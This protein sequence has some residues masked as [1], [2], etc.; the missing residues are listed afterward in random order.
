V[1]RL[2]LVLAVTS[3]AVHLAPRHACAQGAAG[4]GSTDKAIAYCAAH[5]NDTTRCVPPTAS[6]PA[7]AV[8]PPSSGNR[9]A[10]TENAA[11]NATNSCPG[12]TTGTRKL[13]DIT[14]PQ[15]PP[16]ATPIVQADNSAQQ[17]YQQWLDE[18][19][20]QNAVQQ[21]QIQQQNEA[22][23]RQD[24]Q[25]RIQ[26]QQNFDSGYEA[27]Q[28]GGSLLYALMVRHRMRSYCKKHRDGEWQL[29]SGRIVA[30]STVQ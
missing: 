3:I 22:R 25:E 20:R 19:N 10:G 30:C 27:G 26:Q 17:K 14:E 7:I 13:S 21:Q 1:K 28:N 9:I 16:P 23:A 6:R 12:C 2:L 5:P 4:A 29:P 24:Q 15:A 11:A 8:P 18:Q